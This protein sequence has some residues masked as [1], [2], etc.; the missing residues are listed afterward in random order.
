MSD[1]GGV[2]TLGTSF[3]TRVH[4]NVVHDVWA[5]AYGGWALY[6]DEGSEGITMDHNLCWNTTDGGFHQ[7]YGSGCVIRNNIFAWNRKL[8]VVRMN[9]KV[10]QEIPCSLHFVNNIVVVR[11]G[12]LVGIGPR[13][14]DGVWAG[15]LW[16]DYSGEKPQFD[17]LDWEGWRACGKEIGGVYADPQ[18]VDADADDFRL[19]PGSPA[20]ALGFEMWDWSNAGRVRGDGQSRFVGEDPAKYWRLEEL[21]AA[22]AYRELDDPVT[23]QPGLKSL[24]V[25][26]KGPNGSKAEFFCYYGRPEGPVPKGGFPGVVMVHGGGGTAYP[27]YTKDWIGLGFAVISIDWY[28]QRPAPGL[29]NVPPSH[30]TVPRIALDGGKRQDHVANVANMVLAHSLLRSFPEVNRDRTVFVGLSWG[31]W[32]GVCVAAVDDRFKG[33]VEIYCGDWNPGRKEFFQVVNGRFLPYAKVPMWWA[34]STNDQNV[35]PR[36]SQDG[37]DACADFAGAAIVNRLPHS[38]IGFDFPSVRRMAKCFTGGAKPLPRLTR[39]MI[40]GG[41]ASAEIL[42]PGAG[43]ASAKLGYTTCTNLPTWKREWKYAPAK[44]E[45]NRISAELPPGAVQCYL[46]AYEAEKSR[47]DDLCGSTGFL[48]VPQEFAADVVVYGSSPA[49][50]TAALKAKAMGL[51]PVV[52]SPDLHIGGLSVSGLGFT[53]SGN[54]SAIG[55]LALDF[56]HRV[57]LEYMKPEAWR[58]QKREDFKAD[59]QDTKAIRHE[60]QTMWTFEPHV[61]ER[62]FADWLAERRVTAR[63]GE[64]L[65]RRGGVEMKDGRIVSIRTLSGNVYRGRYFIDAT[66]EGDLMAA[67]G[68]PYRV[69]REDC[70]EFGE[71][72][73]GNQAGVLHHRHHFR[74]WK[75]SPYKTPGDPSSG[76]CAEVDDAGPGV[77]GAGDRRVQAYCY[78]VC[79]TDDPRNRIPFAKPDGYDPARYELLARVY[80]KG[81]SE[82][83]DKF[84]RIANHKTDTN[85]HGPFN[86]DYLGGSYEWPEASYARRAE[87]A[88]AHRD[89]QMGLYYFIANDPSVPE[90]V[91]RKMSKWGLAK[92][93]FADNGGWPYSLYVRE[94]RRMVGEYVMTEHDCLG[95]PRHPAQGRP[96]GPVGMGSY[97]L[98]SHH[99]RRYVTAEGFVQN[100]GDIGI[101]PERP[102]GIDYGALVPRRAD[103]RNLLV[104][105]A[106]SATHTAFGS[107]RM[108]P[109]F[110]V[111]GESAATA[112][113]IAAKGSRDVQD[114]P[115]AE[116][117]ARLRDDGQVLDIR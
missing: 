105:V 59:R 102:Y 107:I 1:M 75:I 56:Y 53:D 87:I 77:R 115:Y 30:V 45:G 12:P 9:R 24:M 112:A 2:Y 40:E 85:N 98:D 65:D 54:T 69:G 108:E 35:T 91:R 66:Y 50:V 111:L 41:V 20:F 3:G 95:E 74:D 71:K 106:L 60:D 4:H 43:I 93:E 6:T 80:A 28:N 82:T 84:D 99:G 92:D 36:T 14:V 27:N 18:F 37:F 104:P 7:H 26:G 39:G 83:F 109:V 76:L 55:G 90:D 70:A 61:A 103:C 48:D 88:K 19:K 81:Y 62:V 52:V 47:F 44:I 34:V 58:W 42:D 64:L 33:C 79:M 78:R 96:R 22:P 114:V 117:A 13:G 17:G 11:E 101:R 110:M 113:A 16:Y 32:Y 29:T 23:A 73:N 31:S 15:N 94:G 51:E 25:S 8:G 21:S 5:C 68:V 63:R 116:L 89:Y 67:A 97:T 49:A 57:Y 100:E 38:H 86:A 72:W 10:V 46:S